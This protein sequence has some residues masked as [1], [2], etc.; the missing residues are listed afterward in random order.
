MA[1]TKNLTVRANK[2]T[3]DSLDQTYTDIKGDGLVIDNK[4]YLND[5][6]VFNGNTISFETDKV[7]K[8]QFM[9]S[10][11]VDKAILKYENAHLEL[12]SNENT[13]TET[14]K[15]QIVK[16]VDLV[17][18][19]STAAEPKVKLKADSTGDTLQV[20]DNSEGAFKN[21]NCQ[22]VYAEKLLLKEYKDDTTGFYFVR[23][24]QSVILK[25]ASGTTIFTLSQ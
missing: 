14:F 19:D 24:G 13:F 15:T 4:A 7:N 3:I 6:V 1:S 8:L 18:L 22:K 21:I 20:L 23:D 16:T 12:K 5:E 11:G 25:N 2:I 10:N 9:N 17:I